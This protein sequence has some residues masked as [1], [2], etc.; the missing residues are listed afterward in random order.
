MN[1]SAPQDSEPVEEATQEVRPAEDTA[2]N[3]G[4]AAPAAEDVNEDEAAFNSEIQAATSDPH[5]TSAQEPA[6]ADEHGDVSP[7]PA[8]TPDSTA[9]PK[10]RSAH[11]VR[12]PSLS[13][14][15]KYRSSSFRRTSTNGPL[16]PAGMLSPGADM[17]LMTPEGD[18][19]PDIYRKQALRLDDL[20][21]ENKRLEK[22]ARESEKRW[23]KSEEELEELREA[24]SDADA[25]KLQA[26]RAKEN[27]SQ[28]G[29]LKGEI[30]ALQRQ[31]QHRG[32]A[33]SVSKVGRRESG[34]AEGNSPDSFRKELESRESTIADMELEISRL[35]SQLSTQSHGCEQHGEQIAALQAS[36]S[37]TQNK[38]ANADQELADVKKSLARAIE[39]AVHEGTER[40]SK[41]TKIRS[42]EREMSE[43]IA[44]RDEVVRKGEMLEKKVEAMNK[45]HRETEARNAS[46]LSA[47]ESHG[48]E[49]AMLKARLASVE[50][51]NLKL[52]EERDRRKK[53]E[54]A[55]V[56][57][58]NEIDELEAE[59]RVR[60]EQR[61][62][63]LEGE[64]F[65]LRR[66]VWRDRKKELQ[67]SVAEVDVEG[68]E[69][70]GGDDFDDIDLSGST[71][72]SR[73]RSFAPDKQQQHS[74]FSTVLNSGLAAFRAATVS[75]SQQ[76]TRPRQDSLLEEFDDGMD[77]AGF[78][79]AAFAQAQREEEARKMVE[80]VR[81]VKR[82]LKDWQGWRLDLVDV[83]RGGNG[84]GVGDIFEV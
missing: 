38:Q 36:L 16:S 6:A 3:R 7:P 59:A 21:K 22:E 24:S 27:E 64:N 46:K 81:E 53:R 76:Q 12:Q 52:R 13:L 40:T 65:D 39:K 19:V 73:R 47:A 84:F 35:R 57:A 30:V 34:T 49:A 44:L 8:T 37:A 41:D 68:R 62:R 80:H 72:T 9:A 69:V 25:L 17:P 77:G 67:P 70:P 78:D 28:I 60:L 82:K 10:T 4:D 45:L 51:E 55:G 2:D 83:R 29:E 74:S 50:N 66:G 23:R 1:S 18:T 32:H 11:P 20:D 5:A 61:I 33:H 14:Q 56:G 75:P 63:E 71:P 58:E 43:A 79:E 48:R 42:L 15:S 26:K 54:T 31:V